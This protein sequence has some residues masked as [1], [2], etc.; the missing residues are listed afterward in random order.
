[1]AASHLPKLLTHPD[2]WTRTSA[3]IELLLPNLSPADLNKIHAEA[4]KRKYTDIPALKSFVRRFDVDMVIRKKYVIEG[5][6]R[7]NVAKEYEWVDASPQTISSSMPG[8]ITVTPL[9][10]PAPL[11]FMGS[12]EPSS[13][14]GETDKV[15]DGFT[16][17]DTEKVK[18]SEASKP[19]DMEALNKV[20]V[21]EIA[22]KLG[23]ETK[24]LN[25]GEI[26]D[27]IS[28]AQTKGVSA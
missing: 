9:P 24:G 20:E 27:A 22:K 17:T 8:L 4:L 1:M 18:S 3:L 26:I 19:V 25:K 28:A 11:L 14:E 7:V 21:V 15:E 5:K 6:V 16:T 12:D 2:L 10:P 23:I 13:S